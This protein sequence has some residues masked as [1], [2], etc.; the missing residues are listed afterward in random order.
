VL[1][2]TYRRQ[3]AVT[4]DEVIA[5]VASDPDHALRSALVGPADD[6]LGTVRLAQL[7]NRMRLEQDMSEPPDHGFAV[8][9]GGCDDESD[10]AEERSQRHRALATAVAE[11][12]DCCAAN[13]PAILEANCETLARQL[14]GDLEYARRLAS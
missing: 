7:V 4:P 11:V 10:T 3:R 2:L 6:R 8:I 14:I 1:R 9:Q 13:W 5:S 12:T